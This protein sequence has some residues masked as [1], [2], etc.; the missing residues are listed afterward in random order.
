MSQPGHTTTR[1]LLAVALLLPGCAARERG[2]A[3]AAQ[4]PGQN[5]AYGGPVAQDD[6]ASEPREPEAGAQPAAVDVPTELYADVALLANCGIE[7]PTVDF[8]YDSANVRRAAQVELGALADC[9]LRP[10]LMERKLLVIGHADERGTAQHDESLSMRRAT[11]VADELVAHGLAATRV[12]IQSM[13]EPTAGLP[14][15]WNDR[16]VVIRLVDEP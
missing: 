13:D 9:L 10:A 2:T 16:R 15:D 6:P 3:V 1:V 4:A 14:P 11:A 12:Q 5:E 7:A 8:E